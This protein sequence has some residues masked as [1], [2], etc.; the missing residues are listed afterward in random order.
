MLRKHYGYIRRVRIDLRIIRCL[1]GANSLDTLAGSLLC[2]VMLL[3]TGCAAIRNPQPDKPQPSL[4]AQWQTR[5]S[6]RLCV[7]RARTNDYKPQSETRWLAD[8]L[9]K[10][11]L[12]KEVVISDAASC[13]NGLV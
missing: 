1:T 2:T 9:V 7:S 4:V 3:A 10:C 5:Y 12:F 8:L 6:S 13:T 11:R